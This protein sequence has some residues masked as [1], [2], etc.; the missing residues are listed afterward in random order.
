MRFSILPLLSV[1]L[2]LAS[3]G[4]SAA[5]QP[6]AGADP[7]EDPQLARARRH[8]DNGVKLFR[9]RNYRGA[10]AEFEEAYRL[11]PSASSLQN[12]ALS[13]KALFRYA[14]AADTLDRLLER[15]ASELS[16][17]ETR[18][19]REAIAELN[20]LVGTVVVRTQPPDAEVTVDGRALSDDE[21][22]QGVR[23]DVGE[24]TISAEADGFGRATKTVR[25]AAS[26]EPVAVQ[27]ELRATRGFLHV[28]S[29]DPDA[30]IA[31]DGVAKAFG[32]WRGPV[33]PGTHRIQIYK[34]G[35]ETFER[36]VT[37]EVG[38]TFEVRGAPGGPKD[39]G[40]EAPPGPKQPPP[41]Q[42]GF[43][44]LANIAALQ[45]RGAPGN[46]K[47]PDN[48]AKIEGGGFGMRAGYRLW[49][50][51]A[52]EMMVEGSRHDISD[53]CEEVDGKCP[54]G[55]DDPATADYQ[56][57]LSYSIS[58]LRIGPNIRIMSSG[59]K[60]R[61]IS[62]VGAGAVRHE[63]EIT[64]NEDSANATIDG[65]W[66]GTNPY[67][68]VELGAQLNLGH[69]LLEAAF[70][71]YIDGTSNIRNGNETPRELYDEEPLNFFGLGLRGGW[72]EWE[73]AEDASLIDP[74]R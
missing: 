25:I 21:R 68:L 34:Q 17:D 72:G 46:I 26:T 52:V 54:T 60:L 15:H 31:V 49:T 9:D 5:Q 44:V 2:V 29:S 42:Q 69:W 58:T 10:L 40:V 62:T 57:P 48:P 39:G 14:D 53:A 65:T 36:M 50:P 30:A 28:I 56:R 3:P 27:L 38:K 35:R 70:M 18:A 41:E 74:A 61:F 7:A 66:Q 37:V 47:D 64:R 6:D 23:L 13:L 8:F 43:Y 73:P 12:V 33:P 1:L 4:T 22:K 11:K 19:V 32:E 55:T 45:P 63:I 51:V 20:G 24:H 16:A 71:A 67:F 59:Q